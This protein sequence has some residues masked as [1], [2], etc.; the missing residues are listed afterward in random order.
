MWS[1][2][3]MLPLAQAWLAHSSAMLNLSALRY[4][5]QNKQTWNNALRVRLF[6]WCRT[7]EQERDAELFFL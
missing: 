4:N 7:R 1:A 5:R 6:L 3:A 2:V